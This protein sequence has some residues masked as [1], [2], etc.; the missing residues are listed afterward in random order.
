MK[1]FLALLACTLVCICIVIKHSAVQS[2]QSEKELFPKNEVTY[3][4]Q[5]EKEALC[6]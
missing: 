6:P 2:V 5:Y 4:T 1:N 3:L